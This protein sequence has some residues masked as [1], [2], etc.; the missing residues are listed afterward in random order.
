MSVSSAKNTCWIRQ[1]LRVHIKM[2]NEQQKRARLSFSPKK[3][4]VICV[5]HDEKY[6]KETRL[7]KF[8]ETSLEK[9]KYA[10]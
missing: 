7:R 3:K 1:C 2:E 6:N 5:I 4:T 8:T 10:R 9:V